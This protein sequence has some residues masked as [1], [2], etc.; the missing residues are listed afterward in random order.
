MGFLG[1]SLLISGII[2][3]FTPKGE[4][5]KNLVS[6]L[7]FLATAI[8]L[9][10]F[11]GTVEVTTGMIVTTLSYVPGTTLILT[12]VLSLVVFLSSSITGIAK[13]Q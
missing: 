10:L 5:S 9:Y 6:A 12:V 13:L 8:L 2:L 11:P 4:G 1:F 3:P 7:L